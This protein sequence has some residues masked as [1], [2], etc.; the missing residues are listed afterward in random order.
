M[1]EIYTSVKQLI[2]NTTIIEH[3]DIQCS[4]G[5]QGLKYSGILTAMPIYLRRASAPAALL[6]VLYAV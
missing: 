5:L 1:S 2:G 3:A 6:Q 4:F